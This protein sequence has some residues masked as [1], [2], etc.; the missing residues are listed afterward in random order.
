MIKL[1]SSR[2]LL[3]LATDSDQETWSQ[4]AVCGD[5]VFVRELNGLSVFRWNSVEA[6]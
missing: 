1:L 5:E 4:L 6:E 2:K 3:L